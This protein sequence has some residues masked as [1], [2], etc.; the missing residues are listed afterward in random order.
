[1]SMPRA[2]RHINEIRALGALFR[3]GPMSRAD[4]ARRLELTRST[5]S[6]IVAA[7][8]N[9]GLVEEDTTDMPDR[10]SRTGR[11]GTDLRLRTHHAVFLGADIGVGHETVVA[12]GLDASII[13]RE[14]QMLDMRRMQPEAVIETLVSMVRAAIDR[15]PVPQA[16]RG[17]S[18]SLPG[19]FTHEGALMRAPLLGWH[20]LPVLEMLRERLPELPAIAVENDANAFA[21]AELY[22]GGDNAPRE[23]L[24]MFLDAGVGGGLVSSGR[25]LRGHLGYAG[26]IGHIYAGEEGFAAIATVPGS[27]ESFVG[28]DAVLARHRF[29]GGTAGSFG[30]FLMLVEAAETPALATVADWGWFLGRGLATLTS[31]LNP[32]TIVLG[33]PVAALFPYA[34]AQVGASLRHHLLPNHPPPLLAQS[35]FGIEGPALGAASMLHQG[36]FSI[37][38]D[39][40]FKGRLPDV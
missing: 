32:Q 19:L 2:V 6:S 11:P 17:L 37:D 5:A 24:Y 18:V 3:G 38:E 39:L 36:M 1:M 28:R 27:L 15:L 35:A 30:E 7:L 8:V 23:A 22:H 34:E 4:L 10:G 16:V 29:H 14:T 25:I 40:V 26:E 9:A 31:I 12:I 13:L 20:N 33:G 21:V